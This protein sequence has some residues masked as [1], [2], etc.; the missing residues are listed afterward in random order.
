MLTIP[1]AN[2]LATLPRVA[3]TIAAL[4]AQGDRGQTISLPQ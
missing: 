1:D 4:T 2:A 3:L